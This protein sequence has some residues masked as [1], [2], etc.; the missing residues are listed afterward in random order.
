MLTC[1]LRQV[2]TQMST[3]SGSRLCLLTLMCSPTRSSLVTS[4]CRRRNQSEKICT[5]QSS[6]TFYRD[7]YWKTAQ[8][9]IRHWKLEGRCVHHDRTTYCSLWVWRILKETLLYTHTH[10]KENDFALNFQE[11]IW[12]CWWI[13]GKSYWYVNWKQ[14]GLIRPRDFSLFCSKDPFLMLEKLF[15]NELH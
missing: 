4:C 1:S 7:L 2:L 5:T 8:A 12:T 11:I 10:T 14:S 6:T 3:R 9:H 15:S 13:L